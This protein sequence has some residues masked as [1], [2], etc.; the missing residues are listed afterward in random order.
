MITVSAAL[1]FWGKG[2]NIAVEVLPCSHAIP[3]PK[4]VV[5]RNSRRIMAAPRIINFRGLDATITHSTSDLF[6][7]DRWRG[8]RLR[9]RPGSAVR[10]TI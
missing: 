10:L 1:N 4:A 8:G 2:E 6:A 7:R 9:T 3:K 5:F